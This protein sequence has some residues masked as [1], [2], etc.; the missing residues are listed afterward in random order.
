MPHV[1]LN[2]ISLLSQLAPTLSGP[3]SGST[4]ASKEHMAGMAAHDSKQHMVLVPHDFVTLDAMPAVSSCAV[5][6]KP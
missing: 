4:E 2:S 1:A 3:R 5:N 6:P